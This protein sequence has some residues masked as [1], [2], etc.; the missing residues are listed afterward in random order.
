VLRAVGI[1][2]L[3]ADPACARVVGDPAA[4]HGVA[5]AAFASAGFVLVG[6]VDLPHKRAAVMA[7]VRRGAPTT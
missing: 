1:G 2:L 3:A 5:R 7:L 6:E 4:S